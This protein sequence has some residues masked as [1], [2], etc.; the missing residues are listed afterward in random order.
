MLLFKFIDCL[1]GI[2]TFS[3]FQLIITQIRSKGA[4]YQPTT[5]LWKLACLAM[6]ASVKD[7]PRVQN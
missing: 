5:T 3:P 1:S 4:Y 7:K 6:L 2:K